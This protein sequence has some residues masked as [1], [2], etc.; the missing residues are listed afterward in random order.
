VQSTYTR[1]VSS[2]QFLPCIQYQSLILK[3][4]YLLDYFE[5]YINGMSAACQPVETKWV[6]GFGDGIIKL[7]CLKGLEMQVSAASVVNSVKLGYP[8]RPML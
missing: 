4:K 3:Y 6:M 8:S 7:L 2:S 5:F 1:C